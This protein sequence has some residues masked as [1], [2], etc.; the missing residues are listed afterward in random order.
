MNVVNLPASIKNG[1]ASRFAKPKPTKKDADVS[2]VCSDIV[3]YKGGLPPV[4]NIVLK[5]TP[6]PFAKA[7]S[8]RRFVVTK[9]RPPM[10]KQPSNA[11]PSI[12]T[13]GSKRNTS[14]LALPSIRTRAATKRRVCYL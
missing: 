4:G 7:H 13:R 14:P 2:E 12:R 11:L 6:P 8:A 9:S 10:P 3:P 5:S 1:S